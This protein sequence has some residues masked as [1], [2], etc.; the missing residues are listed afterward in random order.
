MIGNQHCSGPDRRAVLSLY[1]EAL[2]KL[3]HVSEVTA[4]RIHLETVVKLSTILDL[5]VAQPDDDVFYIKGAL[6]SPLEP[7]YAAPR[8]EFY[9]RGDGEGDDGSF[10]AGYG[11]LWEWRKEGWPRVVPWKAIERERRAREERGRDGRGMLRETA[12][13]A[14]IK[15]LDPGADAVEWGEEVDADPGRPWARDLHRRG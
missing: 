7:Q 14:L 9:D 13:E 11:R 1:R 5:R 4:R 6:L 12:S 10:W 2:A 3:E 15:V 8:L